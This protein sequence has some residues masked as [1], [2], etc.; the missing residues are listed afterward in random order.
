ML[1]LQ[2]AVTR[3]HAAAIAAFRRLMRHYCHAAAEVADDATCLRYAADAARCYCRL[4]TCR[5][6]VAAMVTDFM[7]MPRLRAP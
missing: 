6:Q 4:Y 7:P 3:C 5:C 1:L 2:H